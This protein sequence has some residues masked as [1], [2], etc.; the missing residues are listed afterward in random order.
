M[1]IFSPLNLSSNAVKSRLVFMSKGAPENYCN[2]LWAAIYDQYNHGRHE[3]ELA[4]YSDALKGTAGP[5]LEAA[6]G[7][8]MVLLPLLA[9][10]LDMYG[11]DVSQEM[12]DVL[13]SKPSA[14]QIEDIRDRISRQNLVDFSYNCQFNAAI[15]PAR[16][17]LH[18]STQDDQIA[19][20]RNV[21]K[22]LVRSGRLLLNFFTPDLRHLLSRTDPDPA[23]E[24]VATYVH[25][26]TGTPV[27]LLFRQVNDL[28]KQLQRI[29]WRLIHEGQSYD[30]DMAIRWIYRSEFELLTRLAGFRVAAL[31]G[32]FSRKPYAGEGEMVW[33]LEKT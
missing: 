1:P 2:R 28:S 19:C 13:L 16:S 33:A 18:L 4:F 11:F 32:G 15:I 25:P 5:I 10:G 31:Y 29:T 6:C 21:H 27:L 3:L 14:M 12:L 17:F 7:T 20:L 22:H 26:Q 9:Q 8:G 24:K 30:S 23:F